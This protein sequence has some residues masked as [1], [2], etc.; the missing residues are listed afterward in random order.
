[1]GMPSTTNYPEYAK[2]ATEEP[3]EETQEEK[4]EQ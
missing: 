4:T 2:P 1:M 3:K